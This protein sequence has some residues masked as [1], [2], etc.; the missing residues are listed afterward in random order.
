MKE[1]GSRPVINHWQLVDLLMHMEG[2][3]KGHPSASPLLLR[4][5]KEL[6]ITGD[7]PQTAITEAN[8]QPPTEPGK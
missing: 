8:D 4:V 1:N 2:G 5:R 6:E 3:N 7:K